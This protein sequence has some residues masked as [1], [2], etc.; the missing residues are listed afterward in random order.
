MENISEINL[1]EKIK[2]FKSTF[3]WKYP[4]NILIDKVKQNLSYIGLDDITTSTFY[5][6]SKEMNY[7]R[8]Y[9]R[10]LA[11]S[12]LTDNKNQ[13]SSWIEHHWIYFSNKRTNV[14]SGE[15][16][17]FHRHPNTITKH[18]RD[19]SNIKTDI[20]YCFYL[21]VPQDLS[22][23]E[24]KLMFKDDNYN[25]VGILPK[26]GDIL[27]FN[28][29]YLHKPNFIHNSN[30]ERIAICS[31]LTINLSESTQNEVLI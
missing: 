7:V 22:G 18:F 9:C 11:V 16:E 31:N 17:M 10:N 2:I 19:L 5:I 26:T 25:Q 29:N 3:D 23:E 14:E 6:Q 12:I 20:S 27:F 1:N 24:G 8:E 21:N 15:A 13:L 4:Q 30:E 28:P